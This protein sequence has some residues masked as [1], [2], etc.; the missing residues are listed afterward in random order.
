MFLS[1]PPEFTSHLM[2]GGNDMEMPVGETSLMS[3]AAP[4]PTYSEGM[5]IM[6]C[7]SVLSL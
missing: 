1:F 3:R 2:Q 6:M 4:S 7:E 5:E